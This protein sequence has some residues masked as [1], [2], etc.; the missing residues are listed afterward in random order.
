ML[1]I[2]VCMGS[3]KTTCIDHILID[4]KRLAVQSEP[5]ALGKQVDGRLISR[6]ITVA[7]K[8]IFSRLRG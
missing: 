6:G 1:E 4:R 5:N 8:L 3:I 2:Q 7:L